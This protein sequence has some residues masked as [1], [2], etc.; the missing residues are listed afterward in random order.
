M[1]TARRAPSIRRRR[2]CVAAGAVIALVL[3]AV[4]APRAGAN[5]ISAVYDASWA[6]LD[7]AEVRITLRE[8]N[9]RYRNDIEVSTLGVPHL[10]SHFRAR[11]FSEGRLIAGRNPAPARYEAYYDLRKRRNQR[12]SMQFVVRAG[13]AVADRGPEDTSRKPPLPEEMRRNILDP[14]TAMSAIREQLRAALPAFTVPIYDGARRFDVEVRT[15]QS[16]YRGTRHFDMT[17]RPIAGFKG[18][19]SDDGDPDTAP[20]VVDVTMTDDS[21]LMML[22]MTVNVFFMP[23]SLRLSRQCVADQP[24]PPPS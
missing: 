1:R 7:A 22:G 16:E 17:L 9:G 6:G 3:I 23:L 21:R 12:L 8:I 10:L 13:A 20:R 15:L 2:G 14:L 4:A 24:C 5:D 18:E 19:S 11:A